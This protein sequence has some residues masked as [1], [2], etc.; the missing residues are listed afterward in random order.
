MSFLIGSIILLGVFLICQY[1][2]I[3]QQRLRNILIIAVILLN[4]VPFPRDKHEFAPTFGEY[5]EPE[6]LGFG[7]PMAI[8]KYYP[9]CETDNSYSVDMEKSLRNNA[10]AGKNY[11]ISN[12]NCPR[13]LR[14]LFDSVMRLVGDLLILGICIFFIKR[15]AKK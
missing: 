1:L 12:D 8:V 5:Y 2:K 15:L 11:L 13:G 14:P 3:K 7:W 6:T 10:F 9:N 4:I